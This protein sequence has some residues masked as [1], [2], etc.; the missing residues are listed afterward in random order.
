M[1]RLENVNKRALRLV[2]GKNFNYDELLCRAKSCTIEVKWKR[3]LAE[4]VYKAVHSL[5][6]QYIC[7][8]FQQK[9]SSYNFR[10]IKLDQPRF[11]SQTYGFYSLRHEGTRLWNSLP[12]HCQNAQNIN[13]FKHKVINYIKS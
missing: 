6:P 5:A 8:I 10:G 3:Q 12:E 4:M 1:K 11:Y 7:D 2:F 9:D 13:D